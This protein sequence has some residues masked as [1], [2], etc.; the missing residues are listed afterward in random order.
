MQKV[1]PSRIVSATGLRSDYARAARLRKGLDDAAAAANGRRAEAGNAQQ[2][3]QVRPEPGPLVILGRVPDGMAAG[4]EPRAVDEDV[5]PAE[6]FDGGVDK[7]L[8]ARR[9]GDVELERE[10][11]F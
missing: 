9:V 8:A 3:V 7:P 2:A 10:V 1:A 6:L 4:P 11:A 5:E